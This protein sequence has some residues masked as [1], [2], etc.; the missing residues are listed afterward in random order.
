MILDYN[1]SLQESF[2]KKLAEEIKADIV[3]KRRLRDFSFFVA[4]IKHEAILGIY[5]EMM[6]ALQSQNRKIISCYGLPVEQF[7]IQDFRKKCL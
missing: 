1:F 7:N 3:T 4:P 2:H 5:F 6:K